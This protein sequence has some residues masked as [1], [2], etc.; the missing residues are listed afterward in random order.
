MNYVKITEEA[1]L[2]LMKKIN[3]LTSRIE[4]LEE[5]IITAQTEKYI[6]IKEDDINELTSSTL[7]SD[8]EE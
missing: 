4:T 8:N 1:F 7:P 5:K 3:S 2:S 6:L